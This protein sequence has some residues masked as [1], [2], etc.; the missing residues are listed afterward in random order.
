MYTEKLHEGVDYAEG[1]RLSIYI[2]V[3]LAA[4]L[5]IQEKNSLTSI[6]V[7]GDERFVVH[8]KDLTK[9]FAYLKDETMP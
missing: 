5:A 2:K 3:P 7:D 6:A 4:E 8:R 9:K 1:L